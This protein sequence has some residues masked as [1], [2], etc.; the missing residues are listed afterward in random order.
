VVHN[1][2][3]K[4]INN[5]N[6][7]HLITSLKTTYK[8]A[9]DWTGDLYCEIALDW[10]YVNKTVDISM[11]RYIKK[12]IQDYGHLLPGRMQKCPYSPEPK[13]FGSNAQVPLPP[14]DMPKLDANSI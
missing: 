12:K 11:P 6:I 5:N 14:N 7:N 4:Y 1:F 9:E 3:I 13:K 8:L 2:G 10:D